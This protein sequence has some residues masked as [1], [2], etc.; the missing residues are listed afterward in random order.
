MSTQDSEHESMIKTPQQLVV[1]MVLSFVVPVVLLIMLAKF[2]LS[3]YTPDE[4]GLTKE[5]VATRIK[6]VA[7][8]TV[9]EAGAGGAGRS[10]E[11]VVKF[12][13]AA[14]HTTGA[15]NAPK[16]GDAAAWAPRIR[17]GLDAML[18]NAIKGKG[19][20]PPKGGVPDLTDLE[21]ARAIVDM[22][23]KSGAS[24]KEPAAPKLAAAP[25]AA[26]AKK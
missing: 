7:E 3:T 2:V 1:V 15:A 24:L 26:A 8:V 14:C 12:A 13:C 25:A 19:G 11:E 17:A 22:A 20:M 4:H 21:L 23:N 16:I 18:K 6:P 10:G 9:S 5:A